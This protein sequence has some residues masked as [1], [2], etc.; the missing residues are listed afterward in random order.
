[1]YQGPLIIPLS[2]VLSGYS[3]CLYAPAR[4]V[5][6]QSG[7]LNLTQLLLD[8]RFVLMHTQA[9]S[10]GMAAFERCCECCLVDERAAGDVEETSAFLQPV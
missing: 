1:M 5:T 6:C 7:I 4:I 9:R 2:P 10:E 3:P 8:S